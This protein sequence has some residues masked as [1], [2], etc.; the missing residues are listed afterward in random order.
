MSNS[1]SRRQIAGVT[2]GF[3]VANIITSL[4]ANGRAQAQP[5]G[6]FNNLFVSGNIERV[7][8]KGTLNYIKN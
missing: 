2:G 6:T 8:L 5:S 7:K 3:V 4:I 1:F